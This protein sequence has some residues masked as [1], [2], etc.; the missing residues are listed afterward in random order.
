MMASARVQ[1]GLAGLRFGD[2][3]QAHP[4][5]GNRLGALGDGLGQGLG[6]AEARV[7]DDGDGAHGSFQSFDFT[8]EKNDLFPQFIKLQL[9]TGKI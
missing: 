3:D 7:I 9:V 4:G 5:A 8:R 1:L 2:R 6:V